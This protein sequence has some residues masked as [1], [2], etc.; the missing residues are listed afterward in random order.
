M[1]P[2]FAY[3]Q[4]RFEPAAMIDMRSHEERARLSPSVSK[5]F[6]NIVQRWL[7]IPIIVTADSDLS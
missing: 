6:F 7:R 3:P 2:V 4:S 5:G 1:N